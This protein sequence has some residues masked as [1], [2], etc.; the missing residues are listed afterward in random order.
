MFG[1]KVPLITLGGHL[2]AAWHVLGELCIDHQVQHV[3][4]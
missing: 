1:L 2:L 4:H 3:G